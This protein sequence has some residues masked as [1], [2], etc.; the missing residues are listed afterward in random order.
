M[1]KPVRRSGRKRPN[2]DTNDD[3]PPNPPNKN[4]RAKTDK[5][6]LNL[7]LGPDLLDDDDDDLDYEEGDDLTGI[8]IEEPCPNPLCDHKVHD[9]NTFKVV[10]P[11]TLNNITDLISLGKTYHCK[12]NMTYFGL[13]LKLMCNLVEPLT[14]LQ[15]MVGLSVI[16]ENMVN[17]IIF[18]LQKLDHKE[19]CGTCIECIYDKPC[20]KI[21]N[22]DMLHT[23]ITGPPGVGKTELGKILGQV[24][25]AMGILSSGHLNIATRSDLVGKYL[26]HTADKTQK[27]IDSC[28]GGVMFIDEA[29]SLGNKE[30]RDSFSKECLDTLNLN[31]SER[32]DFLVIIAGYAEALDNCFFAY[33]EG[34]RR[35][36]TFRY[37]IEGYSGSELS[38]IFVLK[39][40]NDGWL[41]DQNI[42]NISQFFETNLR[43]FPHFGGD[44]ESFLLNCKVIHGRRV[45][46]MDQIHK[47]VLSLTDINEGLEKFVQ[48]RKYN[49]DKNKMSDS[50]K[51]IYL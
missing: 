31:M 46:F 13:N 29:Y 38:E 24:Y 15:N 20:T 50:V 30:G 3:P 47:K 21:L 51:R 2:K 34:L 19:K 8:V 7:L 18:F 45:V 42:G 48:H 33:N 4:K 37:D 25:K 16:K 9:L 40:K 39:I 36:F 26:G 22:N 5:E 14:Q 35:R 11:K 27:F 1:V 10:Y 12:M 43:Y 23:V 41:I 28:K 17:Q 49:E 32:R 6:L 44:I